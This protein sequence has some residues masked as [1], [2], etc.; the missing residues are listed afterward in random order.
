MKKRR[1]TPLSKVLKT[2]SHLSGCF[3]GGVWYQE[4]D[5]KVRVDMVH[6]PRNG[7]LCGAV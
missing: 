6:A 5:C 3:R 2:G 4:A 1:I 7:S